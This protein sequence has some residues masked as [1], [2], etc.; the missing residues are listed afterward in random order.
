MEQY[1][2]DKRQSE[3]IGP[4]IRPNMLVVNGNGRSSTLAETDLS[5]SVLTK[6]SFFNS[7]MHQSNFEGSSFDDCEFDGA[8]MTGCSFRGVELV[9]CDVDRL[10]INGVNIG[11]LLRL[12]TGPI[13]EK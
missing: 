1:P 2:Q 6:T 4:P 3:G 13:G 11:S 9:N 12:L 5:H 10:V 8:T 7:R